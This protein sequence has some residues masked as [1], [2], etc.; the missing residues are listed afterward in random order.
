[1]LSPVLVTPP[2]DTPVS[3]DEAKV[4]LRVDSDD[5]DT[6]IMSLISAAT[7]HLDGFTG[8]L[9]RC[10]M[11][12]TWS[13][14]YEAASGDLVLPIRPVSRVVSV[15]GGFSEYR[16]LKDGRGHF[17]RLN[18]GASWP[19]GAVVVEF[20]AGYSEVPAPLHSAMLLHI[21]T[22]YE[23]RETLAEKVRPTL[24]YEALTTPYSVVGF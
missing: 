17:L 19:A 22:M 15:T 1:M 5:E 6:L 14:E 23:H 3:L 2:T 18:D 24:A 16:F 4:H 20:E 11:L 7:G 13:Q 12:Q 9:G 10:I 21:G 8:I